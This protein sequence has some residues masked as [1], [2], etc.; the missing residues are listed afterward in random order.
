MKRPSY[1]CGMVFVLGCA[2]GAPEAS[3]PA[4]VATAQASAAPAET[5]PDAA[6]AAPFTQV[7]PR[8]TCGAE[9]DRAWGR[10]GDDGDP[11]AITVKLLAA[12][13]TTC[14]VAAPGLAQ[15]ARTAAVANVDARARALADGAYAEL[16]PICKFASTEPMAE[17]PE[18]PR[19][20]AKVERP[21][22]ASTQPYWKG[23]D[24]G[25]LCDVNVGTYLFIVAAEPYLGDDAHLL[26]R[27]MLAAAHEGSNLKRV[28]WAH[29]R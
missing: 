24:P 7:A 12:F 22:V 3:A 14:A 15:A 9:L 2:G 26:A 25:I 28:C 10:I 16:D 6:V 23:R 4:H 17:H 11:A 19:C 13:A 20:L 21:D 8:V 29:H 5:T 18:L 27:L 1:L